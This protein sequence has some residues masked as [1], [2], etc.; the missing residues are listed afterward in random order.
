M[1][2]VEFDIMLVLQHK[3]N[4]VHAELPLWFMGILCY[5][6]VYVKIIRNYNV[7]EIYNV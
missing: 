2:D 7:E 1:H 5:A 4:Q 3:Y 6:K